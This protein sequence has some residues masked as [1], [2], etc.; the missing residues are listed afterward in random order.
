M[1][2]QLQALSRVGLHYV[3]LDGRPLQNMELQH[4]E[5]ANSVR[6]LHTGG[7]ACDAQP[8]L[9]TVSNAGIPA[10]LTTYVDPKLIDV[11]FAPLEATEVVGIEVQKGDWITQTAM[12]MMVEPTGQISTYDD[13]SNTGVANANVNYPQRQSYHYQVV[14]QWGEKE[15]AVAGAGHVDWANQ[16]NLASVWTLNNFQNTSYFFGIRGIANYGLLNDPALSAPITPTTKV[17]G[18]TG[19]ANATVAEI[20]A[21]V[22]KVYQKLNAQSLGNVNLKTPMILAMS[23]TAQ[24]N[25]VKTT[26]FNVNVMAQIKLNYPNM[27]IQTAV[28]YQTA[29]GELVQ[30]IVRELKGQ[31]T[32]DTAFTE[33]MRAH[34]VKIEL[35]SFAQKKS[36]GT[37]GTVIYR[38]FL[39]AQMLGV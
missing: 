29:S 11:L 10:F 7:F 17:A 9:V 16:Q 32:A 4:P 31:R 38:P 21:D 27:E 33:K 5:A 2:A 14:T 24:G 22:S 12:F 3:G 1:N 23:P 15:L 28:Q 39:I 6:Y 35:S 18:G 37:W 26:D 34:P 19:W 20:L 25:M 13:Y 36:Q 8:A 30:L